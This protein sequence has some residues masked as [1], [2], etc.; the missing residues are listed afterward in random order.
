MAIAGEFISGT[1]DTR[2][3]SFASRRMSLR[4][5]LDATDPQRVNRALGWISVGLGVVELL[6]PRRLE[7]LIGTGGGNA[8]LVRL[9]GVREIANGLGLLSGRAPATGAMARVAGDAL[10]LALLARAAQSPQSQPLRLLAAASAVLGVTAVDAY[11]ANAHARK[12]LGEA[13]GDVT[14]SERLIIDATPQRLYAFWHNVENLP[15]VMTHLESVQR[16]DERRSHWV[17]KAPAGQSV[18]WDA[19]IVEDEPDTLLRWST[20]AGSQVRHEGS[21]RFAPAPGARG[22][23]VHVQIHYGIPGGA[24]GAALARLLGQD[25]GLQVKKD[26]RA[27]KQF[28]ETGERATTRGQPTGQRSFIGE[29]LSRREP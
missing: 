1:A 20:C 23:V 13:A 9:C 11:A 22:T 5:S 17:A 24:A 3:R 15:Q 25:P 18:E 2:D 8:R 16:V 6:A 7:R 14:V 4:A 28:I 26:L 10:D 29:T 21:V 12:A 19:E 27:L